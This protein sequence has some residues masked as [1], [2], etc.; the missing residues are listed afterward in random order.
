M[1]KRGGG[2][3]HH[4]AHASRSPGGSALPV[5]APDIPDKL[6]FRIGEVAELCRVPTYVLRF[7]QTEFAQLR[8]GKSGTGQRLYR[9]RDVEM[10]L[11][12]KHLLHEAGYTIAGAKTVLA[13]EAA[14]PARL[15]LQPE[16]PL[17]PLPELAPEPAPAPAETTEHSA[18]ARLRDVRAGL[19]EL[20][21]LLDGPPQ[22]QQ[23]DAAPGTAELPA[24]VPPLGADADPS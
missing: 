21:H 13:D 11:R 19:Q 17:A 10:A 7:W 24:A 14:I 12:I 2:P 1:A 20:L 22:A 4:T 18:R 23:P 8:P 5:A 16:L 9:R 15:R 6:Y 3:D